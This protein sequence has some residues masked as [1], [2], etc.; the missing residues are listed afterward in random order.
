MARNKEVTTDKV[1]SD[2]ISLP[3]TEQIEVFKEIR[4]YLNSEKT[5]RQEQIDLLNSIDDYKE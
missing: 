5:S 4:D 3:L 1:Y 2:F